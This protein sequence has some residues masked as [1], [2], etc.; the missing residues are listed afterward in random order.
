MSLLRLFDDTELTV[1]RR[2]EVDPS[3]VTPSDEVSVD[4][5]LLRE[6]EPECSAKVC[7]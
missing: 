4:R 6:L 5:K 7:S 2:Y 3:L 1:L